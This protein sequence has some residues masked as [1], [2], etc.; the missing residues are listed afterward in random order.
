MQEISESN[1]LN[2]IIKNDKTKI[3]KD[4][5]YILDENLDKF[6]NLLK[7]S[8][9]DMINDKLK[10]FYS[11]NCEYE[12]ILYDTKMDKV[13]FDKAIAQINKIKQQN[14][15]DIISK[16]IFSD[17]IIQL[18]KMYSCNCFSIIK[19]GNNEVYKTIFNEEGIMHVYE[20]HRG[21]LSF[22]I[23]KNNLS[24]NVLFTI[25]YL[26]KSI[27]ARDIFDK[28]YID[29]NKNPEYFIENCTYFESLCKDQKL[30]YNNN[31]E[32]LENE[33]EE[34]KKIK[35]ELLDQKEYYEQLELTNMLYEKEK[36]DFED[37]KKKLYLI[38]EKLNLMK[39]YIEK[40]KDELNQL[41]IQKIDMD[42]FF[43]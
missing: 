38:K 37:E 29:Y 2:E 39:Q 17:Q 31:L 23:Y 4:I 26:M 7:K 28:F 9:G 24:S 33:I 27:D 12:N 11:G 34:V 14:S 3:E 6:K 1:T 15:N 20:P 43:N 16:K 18:N 21:E 25:K 8:I 19:G 42:T 13:I 35:Q 10:N 41:K 40:E 32:I 36:I 5:K 22:R 30:E